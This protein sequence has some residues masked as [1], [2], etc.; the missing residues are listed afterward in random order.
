M[1]LVFVLTIYLDI[2]SF[3][4]TVRSTRSRSMI[5]TNAEC[6]SVYLFSLF[7]FG[8]SFLRHWSC[9]G[10]ADRSAS[11]ARTPMLSH[12]SGFSP[13]AQLQRLFVFSSISCLSASIKTPNTCKRQLRET[14]SFDIS[15]T[16]HLSSNISVHSEITW[17]CMADSSHI[18]FSPV[19][20][21]GPI[22]YIAWEGLQRKMQ[23][24]QYLSPC[25]SIPFSPYSN[26]F[27]HF[28][29][30]KFEGRRVTPRM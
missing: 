25:I 24:Q 21:A 7:L 23:V 26:W 2:L 29:H 14:V 8:L 10:K 30:Q 4:N 19:L 20:I 13:R 9:P 11:F 12:F 17:S 27:V 18:H 6:S 15:A 22:L 1:S 28:L 16:G 5:C 3:P